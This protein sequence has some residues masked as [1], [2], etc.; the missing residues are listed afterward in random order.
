MAFGL[1][2]QR[3]GDRLTEWTQPIFAVEVA[4]LSGG[5]MQATFRSELGGVFADLGVLGLLEIREGAVRAQSGG[6]RR[7]P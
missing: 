6:R 7:L 5:S 3:L 1:R 2:R 4:R